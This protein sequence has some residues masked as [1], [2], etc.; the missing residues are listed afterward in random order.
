M[1]KNPLAHF[2]TRAFPSILLLSLCRGASD[3]DFSD[4]VYYVGDWEQLVLPPAVASVS[5]CGA[6]CK[7]KRAENCTAFK[8]ESRVCLVAER[9]RRITLDGLAATIDGLQQTAAYAIHGE[10]LKRFG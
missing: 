1:T 10:S 5:T 9:L 6:Q 3:F 8:F 2:V 4:N 7:M